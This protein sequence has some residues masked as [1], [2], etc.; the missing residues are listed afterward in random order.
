MLYLMSDTQ[1]EIL[2][3][4][5]RGREFIHIVICGILNNR[6]LAYFYFQKSGA[7]NTFFHNIFQDCVDLA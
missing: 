4:R 7:Y 3:E 5:A 6:K 1:E 2:S